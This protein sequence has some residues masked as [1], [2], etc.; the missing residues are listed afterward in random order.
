M[1]A[2]LGLIAPIASLGT[3]LLGGMAQGQAQQQNL[4]AQMQQMLFQAGIAKQNEQIA[5]QNMQYSLDTG[6]AGTM[7]LGMAERAKLGALRTAEGASGF[8]IGRGT[9]SNVIQSQHDIAGMEQAASRASTLKQAYD[10]DIQAYSASEQ[11]QALTTG[12]INVA[13]SKSTAGTASMLG[14]VGAV[15]DKWAGFSKSGALQDVGSTLSSAGSAISSGFSS[16]VG[17]IGGG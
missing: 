5:K 14:T 10:Y 17:G 3:S 6:E 4:Q 11:A 1:T 9:M 12:A 16:F 13:L 2:A 15:A 7:A 8:Q